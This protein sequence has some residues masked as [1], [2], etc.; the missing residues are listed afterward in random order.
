MRNRGTEN[1]IAILIAGVV[2]MLVGEGVFRW[3]GW[4]VVL[5][6]MSE[7]EGIFWYSVILGVV[8]AGMNGIGL[9][10]TSL[11]L[12]SVSLGFR[13]MK[14]VVGESRVVTILILG[15]SGWLADRLLGMSWSWLEVLMSGGLFWLMSVWWEK[16]RDLSIRK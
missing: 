4:L 10:L 3:G 2:L 11:V 7:W 5:L 13:L 15:V 12:L 6:M 8:L 1:N 9:G 16:G 14:G